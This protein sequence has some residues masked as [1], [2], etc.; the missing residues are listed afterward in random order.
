MQKTPPQKGK[1]L[2]RDKLLHDLVEKYA[3]I[4]TILHAKNATPPT[5][6]IGRA[7][8]RRGQFCAPPVSRFLRAN[9]GCFRRT[10]Q[11][12]RAILCPSTVVGEFK[13]GL[14]NLAKCC[15]NLQKRPPPNRLISTNFDAGSSN[16]ASKA[17]ETAGNSDFRQNKILKNTPK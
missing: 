13:A 7:A 14:S 12:N 16:L 3:E 15:K 4:T 9:L 17:S 6:K 2:L 1:L 11:P 10:F 5:P 8:K